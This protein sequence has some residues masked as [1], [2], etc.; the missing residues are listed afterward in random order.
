MAG[1]PM[2]TCHISFDQF[3]RDTMSDDAPPFFQISFQRRFLSPG[4]GNRPI[5]Y[6]FQYENV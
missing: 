4:G 6:L 3:V 2:T 5:T 1:L